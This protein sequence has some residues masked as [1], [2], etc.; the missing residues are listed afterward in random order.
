[1]YLACFLDI[2][3]F[4]PYADNITSVLRSLKI[5]EGEGSIM[6]GELTSMEGSQRRPSKP[7]LLLYFNI[8]MV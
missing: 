3:F 1:M 5:Y 7:Y 8:T 6:G 4:V 2:N